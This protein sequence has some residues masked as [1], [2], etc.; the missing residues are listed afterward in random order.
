MKGWTWAAL[1]AIAAG[2][3]ALRVIPVYDLVFTPEGVNYLETD[4][5]YHVRHA[6]NLAAHFPLR[7]GYDPYGLYPDGQRVVTGPFWDYALAGVPWIVSLGAPNAHT[8]EVWSAWLP[9]LLGALV[10][11]LGFFVA[12]GLGCGEAMAVLAGLWLAA[13]PGMFL[14]VTRLGY[15]D[16]HGA[17]TILAL[18]VL[19]LLLR[20]LPPGE[21]AVRRWF[22]PAGVALGLCFLNRPTVVFLPA[23]LILTLVFRPEA[24]RAVLRASLTALAVFAPFSGFYQSEY[25]WISLGAAALAALTARVL[26]RFPVWA[27]L[28][29]WVG[30]AG[31]MA[32]A[33]VRLRPDVLK[34]SKF[35]V[36]GSIESTVGELTPLFVR[37]EWY[38]VQ[39]MYRQ[40]GCA[41]PLGLIGIAW[42]AI[43]AWR[44]SSARLALMAVWATVMTAAGIWQTRSAIYLSPALVIL[45]V[46]VL[47]RLGLT[48]AGLA[49]LGA[50]A[51]LVLIAFQVPDA[52]ASAHGGSNVMGDWRLALEW[53]RTHS[54]EPV[55]VPGWK[56]DP[57]LARYDPFQARYR[58][59]E[60]PSYGV[61]VWW[62]E[63]Y[64]TEYLAH[65]PPISNGTQV[66]GIR[67]AEFYVSQDADAPVKL[68]AKYLLVDQSICFFAGARF[69]FATLA[70]LAGRYPSDFYRTIQW[71]GQSVG[72]FRAAYY[73]TMA[74]HLY[75]HDGE[76][77][78]DS[79]VVLFELVATD[80]GHHPKPEAVDL[81]RFATEAEAAQYAAAHE[82]RR[83]VYGCIDP[84][85]SCVKLDQIPSVRL[86]YSSDPN[87]IS[88]ERV[89]RAV[90]VF[91]VA[92]PDSEKPGTEK[93]G[94]EKP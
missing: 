40:A 12:R 91:E 68:G 26:S 5:W 69:R 15:P 90:K 71:N 36:P 3:V 63:G 13:T 37:I 28:P 30:L 32:F 27:R 2:S 43:E 66:G 7:S 81:Q 84:G 54:P 21:N 86:A 38:T 42:A 56:G 53:L 25:A 82:G 61:G 92:L 55:S 73:H 70:Q 11:F 88:P 10:P 47:A 59:R 48:R 83:F 41:W 6:Q 29:S 87:P 44:K 9:A 50:V 31:A 57:F 80:D 89:I 49:R 77:V 18:S 72:V 67:M 17:E 94:P 62:D 24:W 75:L 34:L 93:P 35:F 8:V 22:S 85:H 16:H 45:A 23:I 46:F 14:W 74:A 1:A 33:I 52:Y 51:A 58:A 79:G 19:G 20:E 64:W 65:R 39:A 76:A 60:R 78:P 4:A